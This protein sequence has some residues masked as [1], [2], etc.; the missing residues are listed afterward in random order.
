M[1]KP[2]SVLRKKTPT[3]NIRLHVTSADATSAFA[4]SQAQTIAAIQAAVPELA[5]KTDASWTGADG[6][7]I[8]GAPAVLEA[9]DAPGPPNVAWVSSLTV[10]GKLSSL[11]VFNGPLTDVPHLCSRAAVTETGE[12]SLF[13]DWRPRAY[14]AYE[15]RK[16]DGT[17]PGPDVLGREA[18]TY[19]GARMT[20]EKN[21]YTPAL[22]AVVAD[23]LSSFEGAVPAGPPTSEFEKLT[24][25]PLV[26]DVR[27]PL[28]E[29][30]VASIVKARAAAAAAW[31]GWQGNDDFRLK[32][33][34]PVNSQYVFDTPAKQNM[35]SALLSVY[36][37]LFGAA[38][39]AKLAAADSGPLDEAYV[40]GAS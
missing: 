8:A 10:E 21:Y 19:S 26:I 9:F 5:P 12:L 37:S 23:A 24:R 3:S 34:A 32:P 35:Y 15:M 28:T 33:G 6:V 7:T 13:I 38:D 31:V 16:E 27:M 14:G 39:G 25:G 29:G 18:F 4:E 11:T 40:G 30:N 20:M 36:S 2:S 1:L 17:Y 22:E